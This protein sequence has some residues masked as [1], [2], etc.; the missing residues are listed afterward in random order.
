MAKQ[1]N[2]IIN[3]LC[4]V[5]DEEVIVV[6]FLDRHE[7]TY[8]RYKVINRNTQSYAGHATRVFSA[9]YPP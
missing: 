6:I 4:S 5:T 3:G 7:L 2:K 8:E 9:E 1:T